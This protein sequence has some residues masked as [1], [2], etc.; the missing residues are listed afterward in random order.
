MMMRMTTR[1][2]ACVLAVAWA[3][4]IPNVLMAED[5]PKNP[6][7]EPVAKSEWKVLC[8]GK[9][10]KDWKVTQF[11]GEG[12]V[13]AEGG[14]IVMQRGAE[15]T[16]INWAGAALPKLNYEV[17]LDA[18]KIDGSDFFCGLVFPIGDAHCSFV[19]GGWGGGVV[20]LSAVDGMYADDNETT[21]VASFEENR[22]YQVRLRV[23][24]KYIQA[25]IDNK[26][27]FNLDTT[28]KK[29]TVHPAVEELKPF[30]VSCYLT[31]AA[32]RN[33]RLRELTK[34]EAVEI[35]KE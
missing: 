23:N 13:K 20:G 28:G 11:G 9:S 30:G 35:P 32:V 4:A 10:L 25:W 31:V 19:V 12:A 7:S 2:F 29:L 15:L 5:A 17:V 3:L 1:E 27:V 34:E 33:I 14:A 16:G 26:R 24:E 21:S 8:D 22:W 6:G 18:K